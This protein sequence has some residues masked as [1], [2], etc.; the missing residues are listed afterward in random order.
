MTDEVKKDINPDELVYDPNLIRLKQRLDLLK[1]TYA[2][3]YQIKK[4]AVTQEQILDTIEDL[5]EPHLKKNKIVKP[6]LL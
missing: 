4:C 3:M 1:E 2:F 5:I 6:A